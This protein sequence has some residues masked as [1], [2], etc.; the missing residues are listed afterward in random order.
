MVIDCWLRHDWQLPGLNRT[1][2]LALRSPVWALTAVCLEVTDR[3]TN[4]LPARVGQQATKGNMRV[5]GV[6]WNISTEEL[7]YFFFPARVFPRATYATRHQSPASTKERQYNG[8]G[9]DHALDTA[10]MDRTLTNGAPSRAVRRRPRRKSLTIS[11]TAELVRTE[12]RGSPS[13]RLPSLADISL[14]N[15]RCETDFDRLFRRDQ[16]PSP[17]GPSPTV[18]MLR[19]CGTHFHKVHCC[20]WLP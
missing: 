14:R 19:A 2:A 20:D 18:L 6:L 13:P 9:L 5:P 10:G 4:Q 16:V 1:K 11:R 7:L 12:Q 15:W 8:A 17:S 3:D